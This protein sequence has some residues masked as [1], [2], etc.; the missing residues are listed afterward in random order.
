VKRIFGIIIPISFKKHHPRTR[1]FG[2]NLCFHMQR[3][4]VPP[5]SEWI[6]FRAFAQMHPVEQSKI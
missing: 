6:R 2:G 1:K 3:M 4:K 5:V